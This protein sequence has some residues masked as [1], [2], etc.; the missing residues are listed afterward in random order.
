MLADQFIAVYS[1]KHKTL[2]VGNPILRSMHMPCIEI[3][4]HTDLYSGIDYLLLASVG[5]FQECN[6]TNDMVMSRGEHGTI[7]ILR[8]ALKLAITLWPQCKK[9][10][11]TDDS[12]FTDNTTGIH[13]CLSDHSMFK[14][15]KTWYQRIVPEI[16]LEPFSKYKSI[17][18]S[19][20]EIV[21]KVPRSRDR[22]FLGMTNKESVQDF[23]KS[24]DNN[25]VEQN[26]RILKVMA[27]YK[28]PS[29]FGSEW[30]SRIST[31]SFEN[32]ELAMNR[33][34]QPKNLK[35]QWGGKPSDFIDFKNLPGQIFE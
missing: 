27:C 11:M 18:S 15:G 4:M 13:V 24:R 1:K 10:T 32:M 29:L 31:H 12:G 34:K 14:H 17:V 8:A 28:I 21:N 5:H 35:A 26:K 16:R 23:I 30:T 33:I 9:L 7:L 22:L 19:I 25:I 2:N 6:V 20:L 3:H